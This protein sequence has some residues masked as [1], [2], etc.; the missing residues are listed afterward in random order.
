MAAKKP[1]RL[2]AVLAALSL[3]PGFWGSSPPALAQQVEVSL[4]DTHLEPAQLQARTG[5]AVALRV[6][7]RGTRVHNLVIPAFYVFLPNLQPGESVTAQFTP[8][9]T[10]TFPY[11]SDTGGRPEPGIRGVL[12]VR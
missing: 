4:Y 9:R 2:R 1:W 3:L 8:D 7:N 10:G 12:L 11:Y 6:V 5:E